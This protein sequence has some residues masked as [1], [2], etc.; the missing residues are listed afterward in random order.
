MALL[1]SCFSAVS[2][3][4]VLTYLDVSSVFFPQSYFSCHFCSGILCLFGLAVRLSTSLSVNKSLQSLL[5][6]VLNKIEIIRITNIVLLLLF[7]GN[8]FTYFCQHCFICHPTTPQIPYCAFDCCSFFELRI[9]HKK[10]KCIYSTHITHISKISLLHPVTP[11][12]YKFIKNWDKTY[13][14]PD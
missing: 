14:T 7:T 6:N 12:Q 11:I 10:I 1:I 9:Q 3:S 5:Q 8:C 13:G 4:V 2:I